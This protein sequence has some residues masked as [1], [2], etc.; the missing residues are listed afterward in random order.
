MLGGRAL[1]VASY[2]PSAPPVVLHSGCLRFAGGGCMPAAG[3]PRADLGS[4]SGGQ[5]W[6]CLVAYAPY[7]S[8]HALPSCARVRS[9]LDC[10]SV[11]S[12]P[13]PIVSHSALMSELMLCALWWVQERAGVQ[14]CRAHV[15]SSPLQAPYQPWQARCTHYLMTFCLRASASTLLRF[16]L[17]TAISASATMRRTA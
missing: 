8:I 17:G 11:S 5:V 2:S 4:R 3:G 1:D 12:L 13:W 14:A 15:C 9:C 6:G 16:S 10:T 7:L